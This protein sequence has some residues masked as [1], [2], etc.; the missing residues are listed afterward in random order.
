MQRDLIALSP[1]T[2]ILDA[3]RLFVEE[4]IHGAPVIG[5]DDRV[6]GVVSTLD[7]LR[8]VR[9]ALEPGAGGAAFD[10]TLT[11]SEAMTRDVIMVEPDTA[12][13]EVARVMLGQRIHRVLVGKDRVVEGMV[14]T[15]DLLRA[16][17][18]A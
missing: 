6:H 16:L 3:H 8:I 2:P 7:L 9:D 18:A 15:F 13:A 4:E 12:L 14:T 11:V 1:D 17:S 10:D 5:E